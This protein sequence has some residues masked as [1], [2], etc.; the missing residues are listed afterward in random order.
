M[1]SVI[2]RNPKGSFIALL[3]IITAWPYVIEHWKAW[4][5]EQF[6][7]NHPSVIV[8]PKASKRVDVWPTRLAKFVCSNAQDLFMLCFRSILSVSATIL[9]QVHRK[10]TQWF[11]Y[12]PPAEE[13]KPLL[14]QTELEQN[15][16]SPKP[17]VTANSTRVAAPPTSV[18]KRRIPGERRRIRD[19]MEPRVT[20]TESSDGEVAT[21][22]Y[23]YNPSQQA[24]QTSVPPVDLHHQTPVAV[25]QR[26]TASRLPTP[27]PLEK[28]RQQQHP[29]DGV[30]QM[31]L[32]SFN[33]ENM[34][35]PPAQSHK[36]HSPGPRQIRAAMEPVTNALR[37]RRIELDTLVAN[38]SEQ[39]RRIPMTGTRPAL[40]VRPTKRRERQQLIWEQLNNHKRLKKNEHGA[41]S[42]S[43]SNTAVA[44]T[45][46]VTAPDAAFLPPSA[47]DHLFAPS[48]VGPLSTKTTSQESSTAPAASSFQFG[49]NAPPTSRDETPR[50]NDLQFG[51]GGSSVNTKEAP[52]STANSGFQFGSTENTS[53]TE[54]AVNAPSFSFGASSGTPGAVDAPKTAA[55]AAAPSF[56]FGATSGA[57]GA[58]DASKTGAAPSFAFGATRSAEAPTAVTNASAPSFAF[59]SSSASGSSE[60]N[61]SSFQFG[62]PVQS[63][64][65]AP[66]PAFKFGSSAENTP[67][68][69]PVSNGFSSATSTHHNSQPSA[70]FQ[71]GGGNVAAAPS[72]GFPN[73]NVAPS[74]DATSSSA[75]SFGVTAAQATVFG[76]GSPS[77]ATNNS[78]RTR[79]LARRGRRVA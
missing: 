60:A 5:K 39:K 23:Y 28:Q 63:P 25:Q 19:S 76:M 68:P 49:T 29:A 41:S 33:K 7:R 26:S 58:S 12:K 16:T 62:N 75:P 70:S 72:F 18:L 45:G 2:A 4:R 15:V 66:Q 50:A 53:R 34:P 79:R 30:N 65:P 44:P 57:P 59:G 52:V 32:S 22:Y 40:I 17:A 61:N 13:T 31:T 46:N 54:M 74:F 77:A 56:A 6:L 3:L 21:S 73:N 47:T 24:N 71:F 43:P 37:K 51:S 9:R 14:P 55:S 36:S 42:A 11:T 27:Y 38:G 69:G 67:A 35:K 10:L 78:A 20:F 64:T 48:Q 8:I 1:L